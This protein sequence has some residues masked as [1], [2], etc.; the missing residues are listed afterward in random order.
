MGGFNCRNC[1]FKAL[2]KI[3]AAIYIALNT[4]DDASVVLVQ[5]V[6]QFVLMLI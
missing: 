3:S 1:I 6:M 5:V 2:N 4:L